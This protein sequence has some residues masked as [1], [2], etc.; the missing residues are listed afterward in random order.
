[1]VHYSLL[2]TERKVYK[3]KAKTE[4]EAQKGLLSVGLFYSNSLICWNY[5]SR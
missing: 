1:M 4:T 5:N 2:D 3:Q